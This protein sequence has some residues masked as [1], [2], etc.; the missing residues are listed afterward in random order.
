MRKNM[1]N[2]KEMNMQKKKRTSNNEENYGKW[3]RN[4]KP[5]GRIISESFN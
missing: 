3:K 4:M 1:E 5:F 2:G